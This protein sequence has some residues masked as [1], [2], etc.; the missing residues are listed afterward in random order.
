MLSQKSTTS[1][2]SQVKRK[3]V[4]RVISTS[5][6][7]KLLEEDQASSTGSGTVANL[8][9][10][11]GSLKRNVGRSL[12]GRANWFLSMEFWYSLEWML[13][14]A[15]FTV[16][17]WPANPSNHGTDAFERTLFQFFAYWPQQ[18]FP[19]WHTN[20]GQTFL[21]QICPTRCE[22][23]HQYPY[24]WKN[25]RGCPA[26]VAPVLDVQIK[27]FS[28]Q[29]NRR[30]SL[31]LNDNPENSTSRHCIFE[32]LFSSGNSSWV[33]LPSRSLRRAKSCSC[34]DSIE[35]TLHGIAHPRS[36][37]DLL[38][39]RTTFSFYI[40]KAFSRQSSAVD[41]LSTQDAWTS[42]MFHLFSY[43]QKSFACPST[44]TTTTTSSSCCTTSSNDCYTRHVKFQPVFSYLEPHKSER[45]QPRPHVNC[46][47]CFR[48]CSKDETFSIA[49]QSIIA[50]VEIWWKVICRSWHEDRQMKIM[51]KLPSQATSPLLAYGQAR[52][53]D[54]CTVSSCQ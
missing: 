28:W 12:R 39:A 46:V 33:A 14:L 45:I 15:L 24:S 5:S 50:S 44:T 25:V 26:S 27:L 42:R 36:E 22:I 7:A 48:T 18:W 38:T 17:L 54:T 32:N 23:I 1:S 11:A 43:M 10:K 16:S 35:I 40:S 37:H 53:L 3:S 20:R 41:W 9:A 52:M 4:G 6:A 29:A 34:H 31:G 51:N 13:S 19:C 49:W 47:W 8:K 30:A 21:F 2:K